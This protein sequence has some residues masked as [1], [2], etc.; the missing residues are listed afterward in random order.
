[1]PSCPYTTH[2]T[3]KE[4][5]VAATG[6]P[7][8][9]CRESCSRTFFFCQNCGEA[10]RPLARFCRH[11]SEPLSF[12]QAE[13]AFNLKA[14]LEAKQNG[15]SESFALSPYGVRDVYALKSYKG[16]LLVIADRSLLVFDIHRLH[17][18]LRIFRTPDGR[19]VRG[20]NVISTTDDEGLL[21]TT[22]QGL[23][24][25]NLVNLES[26]ATQI[27]KITNSE[28]VI[29]HPA[30]YCAG[31]LYFLE[32][33]ESSKTSRLIRFPEEIVVT[34]KG[35]CHPA[36]VTAD[37]RIF[38][39]TENHM[40]LYNARDKSV[41]LKKS[42]EYLQPSAHPA[43][44]EQMEAVYLV[45]EN[46]LWRLDLHEHEMAPSPLNTKAVGD[47]RIAASGNQLFIARTDALL[48]L[49]PFGDV[50][51]D[52]AKNF[53]N[54]RSDGR[55]PEIYPQHILFTSHGK[56]GG[57]EV[58]V[59]AREN[60]SKFE[61]FSY[62]KGLACTPLLSLGRLIVAVGEEQSIELRVN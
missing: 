16:H 9:Y 5:T 6:Q 20:A 4:I 35:V 36:L 46:N 61:L 57:S 3:A 52:S 50:K 32:H 14:S 31:E 49:D 8:S 56:M 38:I 24:Q 10:N 7:I 1:M 51:W 22:A 39:C 48:V 43:Y 33:Q 55:P 37:D 60:L 45:G 42:P 53:L 25:L 30:F 12:A 21:V 18:P 62:E 28:W 17:E 11:C 59:H 47:P 13:T 58:R 26:E 54:V 15:R 40:A 23:Y 41:E 34:L 27:Y 19:A 2:Q 44:S 29:H